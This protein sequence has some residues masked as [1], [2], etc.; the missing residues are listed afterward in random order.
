MNVETDM[1]SLLRDQV[2]IGLGE[3]VRYLP[4]RGMPRS[5]PAVISRDEPDVGGTGGVGV[6]ER[7]YRVTVAAS[8]T[9]GVSQ[10][11]EGRDHMEFS[12]QPGDLQ[13]VVGRLTRVLT[14]EPGAYVLEVTQ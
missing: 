8:A 10:P 3:T 14:R 1:L 12:Q 2:A 9:D 11:A 13:P 5:I 7:R 6:P 4:Y